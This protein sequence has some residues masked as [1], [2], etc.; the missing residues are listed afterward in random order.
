MHHTRQAEPTAGVT[1]RGLLRLLP[2]PTGTPFTFGYVLVLLATS[3][4]AAYAPPATVDAL[5]RG[6]STDMAHLARTPLLSLVTSALW[7]AGGVLST[8][9]IGFLFVLTALERRIG[10]LRTGAVF[11]AGHVLTTLATELPVGISVAAGHLPATSLHRF[12]YGISFG[13]MASVGALAGLLAPAVRWS[14]LT[15]VAFTLGQALLAF[16]DPLTAWGHPLALC[17]GV[18]SWPLVRRWRAARIRAAGAGSAGTEVSGA[19]AAGTAPPGT[20]STPVASAGTPGTPA[21]SAGS[22]GPAGPIAES[23][24]PVG[25]TSA[26]HGIES[27]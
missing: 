25:N 20:P 6:S 9:A 24:Q 8:S 21:A 19:E 5:L 10:P 26:L 17:F 3:L 11:L 18:A 1:A 14:L 22:P 4:F 16:V 7:V 12:D 2:T 13:L 23:E 15:V 27:A